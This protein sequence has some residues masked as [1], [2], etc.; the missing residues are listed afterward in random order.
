[1]GDKI[2]SDDN[3]KVFISFVDERNEIKNIFVELINVD[4][5]FVKFKTNDGNIVMI[6]SCRVLKIK[7]KKKD[8]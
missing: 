2:E 7:E 5:S 3:E 8:G 1:M 6:P 4:S